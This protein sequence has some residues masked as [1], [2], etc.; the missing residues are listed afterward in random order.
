MRSSSVS[1]APSPN[2]RM[3]KTVPS[4]LSRDFMRAS[5]RY[6]SPRRHSADINCSRACGVSRHDMPGHGSL[7]I[8]RKIHLIRIAA[9]RLGDVSARPASALSDRV[10]SIVPAVRERRRLRDGM[11]CGS[12]GSKRA[13]HR[14]VSCLR[15]SASWTSPPIQLSGAAARAAHGDNPRAPNLRSR[16]GSC[17]YLSLRCCSGKRARVHQR[18]NQR[19]PVGRRSCRMRKFESAY[20]LTCTD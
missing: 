7:Q 5:S 3:R 16:D 19:V 17:A 1:R 10:H 20:S 13:P 8:F 12:A 2:S 11:M 14:S 6:Q 18:H 4:A 15:N 9:S